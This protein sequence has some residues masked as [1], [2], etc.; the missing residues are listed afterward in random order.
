M[1]NYPII[2]R[3]LFPNNLYIAQVK[4]QEI[5][6]IKKAII[7]T[8]NGIGKGKYFINIKMGPTIK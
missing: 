8:C 6:K 2:H 5:I 3:A 1:H 7:G 4:N